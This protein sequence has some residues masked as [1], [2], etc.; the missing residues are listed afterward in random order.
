MRKSLFVLALFGGLMMPVWS[1]GAVITYTITDVGT[2]SG[3][4]D[5]NTADTFSGTGFVGIY[6]GLPND[7]GPQTPSFAHL[8]GL[9]NYNGVYSETEMQVDISAL[10]GS[11]V[12]SAILSYTLLD[13][14]SGSQQVTVTSYSADG[15]LRFN[16][17][18]PDNLGTVTYTST[19]LSANSVDVTTLVQNRVG[20]DWLG[21][22]LSPDG[23]GQNFQWTYTSADH[24]EAPDSALVRLT[25]EY[26]ESAVPEPSTLL[27][28]SLL[29]ALGLAGGWHR[30]RKSA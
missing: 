1:Y 17:T 25:V 14:G 9:E 26:S 8:L 20:A 24:G 6:P 27:I 16:A 10:A 12:T 15:T 3:Y 28:W 29:G 2:F 30:R 5:Y 22:F 18:P 11:T 19:G 13:G 4:W 21:L 7:Y 23:P